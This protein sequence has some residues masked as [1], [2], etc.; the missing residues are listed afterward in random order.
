NAPMNRKHTIVVSLAALVAA[1]GLLVA[2]PLNPPAGPI[3]STYKT[4]T[5]VEPRT[6]IGAA[7]TPGD[8][9]NV[10]VINQ[11]GSYYLTGNVTVPS[12]KNGIHVTC[13]GVTIDLNGF[14]IRGNTGALDGILGD[15]TWNDLT[16]K[17]GSIES[18]ADGID[19]S[20]MWAVHIKDVS[21]SQNGGT[22]IK[23]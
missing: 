7:T 6:A 9:S 17:N 3:A 2:G 10:Y 5:E 20:T 19:V 23:F 22:G 8:A 1:A 13:I 11:P 18:C 21:V 4:L 16:I 15:S 14:A 12:A